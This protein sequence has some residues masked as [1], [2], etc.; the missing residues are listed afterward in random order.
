SNVLAA[1]QAGA[2]ERA[3]PR[4]LLGKAVAIGEALIAGL[5]ERAD[6]HVQLAGSARRQT[7]SVKDLDLIATTSRP[8][9]LAKS[10]AALDEIES[11][12]AAGDV[13]ARARTH[14]G[15]RVELRIAKPSQLGN[16]LQHF[17]GS[18]RHNAALREASVR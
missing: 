6:A 2:A 13:G 3:A 14:A 4:I 9:A 12:S 5:S 16:L 7:D 10:L 15:L 1:L 11:V 17:T 18:A 8:A